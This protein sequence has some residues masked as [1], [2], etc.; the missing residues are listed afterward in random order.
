MRRA[1]LALILGTALIGFGQTSAMG[2]GNDNRNDNDHGKVSNRNDNGNGERRG[3]DHWDR[4]DDKDQRDDSD[5]MDNRDDRYDRDDHKEKIC[6]EDD[7]HNHRTITVAHVAVAAHMKHRD[8]MGAC[9][10]S[11]SR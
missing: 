8:K 11:P 3:A 4:D 1:I 5:D 2:Q 7:D 10:G 6:H 9:A